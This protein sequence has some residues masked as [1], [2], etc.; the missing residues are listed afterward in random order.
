MNHAAHAYRQLSVQGT[1]PLGLV[2]MLYDGAIASIERA[3]T[4][5]EVNNIEE[6][7]KHLNRALAIIA[8]LEGTLNF[9]LGGEVAHTLKSLY[10]YA[11]G[12]MLKGN[13]ENS[14]Q[15]LRALIEKVSTVREAWHEADQRPSASP[16]TPA[17]GQSSHAAAPTPGSWQVSA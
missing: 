17:R 3:I 4:A 8:Q 1:S 10:L 9:E 6:K 11:R 14:P 13:I 2:V 7:C 15:T 12:E 5:I 16:S